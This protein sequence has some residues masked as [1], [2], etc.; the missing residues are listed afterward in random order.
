M[1]IRTSIFIA[2]SLDGF[3]ARKDGKLDWLDRA[4]AAA[5]AGEDGGFGAFMDSVDVLVMG[6]NTFEQV[7]DFDPWPYGK[8]PVVVM[9]SKPLSIPAHLQSTVSSSHESPQELLERLARAGIRHVY[10]DGGLTIQSFLRAYLIDELTVTLVPIVLGEGR[11]LFGP[12]EKDL[13]LDHVTTKNLDGGFVQIKYR[14][15]KGTH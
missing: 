6:R 13:L 15:R 1:T 2:C 9:S 4:N 8:T 12:V 3:I 7:L 5:S 11:S 14:V 10:V